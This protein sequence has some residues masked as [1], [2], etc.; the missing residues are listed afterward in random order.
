MTQAYAVL[1]SNLTDLRGENQ[2][3]KAK[4]QQVKAENEQLTAENQRLKGGQQTTTQ[5]LKMTT[6]N[7]VAV[8]SRNKRENRKEET[9]VRSYY[10]YFLV[11]TV[12][13]PERQRE[14]CK[15]SWLHFQSS[16][17]AISNHDPP[18]QKTWEEA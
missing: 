2:Q 9:P 5:I 14:P 1:E 6:E 17:Y 10:N 18:D 8:H 7:S 11:T 13:L 12:S 16:C 3:V 15:T 4:I